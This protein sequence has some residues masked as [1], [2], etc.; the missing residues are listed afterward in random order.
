MKKYI[1]YDPLDCEFEIFNDFE[2]AKEWLLEG[3]WSDEG[4]P[5]EFINGDYLIAE[6]THVSAVKITDKKENYKCV[7]DEVP[8]HCSDCDESEGCDGEEWPYESDFDYVGDVYFK[9]VEDEIQGSI[10]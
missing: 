10:P 2:K 3:D 7:N 4:F 5:E 9:E 8:A 1:A 6:V